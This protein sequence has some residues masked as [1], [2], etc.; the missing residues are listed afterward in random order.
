MR[1]L[2]EEQVAQL[3]AVIPLRSPFGSRDHAMIR[4]ALFTGLRV[5]ELVGLDVGL[6]ADGD[7][8][9]RLYLD[10]PAGLA[11]CRRSRQINLSDE[12]RQAIADL[13]AFLVARGFSVA[14][15]QPLLQNRHHQRLPVR[16]VQGLVQR[17]RE[18]ADLA[19]RATPHALR[20]SFASESARRAPIRAVQLLLGHRSLETT[21]IYLHTQPEDLWAAVRR[22]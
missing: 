3:L 16:T 4:L 18:M 5:S 12:A 17:Y 9:P 10:L 6:V 8:H 14:P 21:Q 22:S 1:I 19:I 11:K 2:D 13:L 15:D 20:H 7:G